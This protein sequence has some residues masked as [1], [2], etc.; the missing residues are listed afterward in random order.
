MRIGK[1]GFSEAVKPDVGNEGQVRICLCRHIGE[2]CDGNFGL[3]R[4]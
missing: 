3:K 4:H 2:E 1:E